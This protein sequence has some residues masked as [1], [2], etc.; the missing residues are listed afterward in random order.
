VHYPSNIATQRA[1]T[2]YRKRAWRERMK[3]TQKQSVWQIERADYRFEYHLETGLFSLVSRFGPSLSAK[4]SAIVYVS[5]N[6]TQELDSVSGRERRHS[7]EQDAAGTVLEVVTLLTEGHELVQKFRFPSGS[8]FVSMRVGF[9]AAANKPPIRAQAFRPFLIEGADCTLLLCG[10]PEHWSVYTLGYQSWSPAGAKCISRLQERPRFSIPRIM[11]YSPSH[12]V[13]RQHGAHLCDWMCAV[14]DTQTK[15]AFLAGFITLADQQG[16]ILLYTNPATGKFEYLYAETDADDVEVAS[17]GEM[18]SEELLFGFTNDPVGALV[19]YASTLGRNMNAKKWDGVPAGWCSWYKYYTRVREGDVL[20]NLVTLEQLRD[21]MPVRY[22]QL[23]DGYQRAVGDWLELDN[24]KFPCGMPFLTHRIQEAGFL[25]G[26]W[27]A[28]FFAT[29]N[30]NLFRRK[31]EMF[32][33]DRRGRIVSGGFST[34]W[35][36]RLGVLDLTHPSTLDWLREVFHTVVHQWGFRYLKLDFLYAGM[37]PGVHYDKNVTRAQAYH[38]ALRLIREVAGDDVFILGCGAPLG[39]SIGLVNGMRI[40]TDVGPSWVSRTTRWFYGSRIESS[41]ESSLVNC[42]TRSFLHDR[43]WINDP[44]CIMLRHGKLT[45]E[46]MQTFVAVLAMT[47]GIVLI[48]DDLREVDPKDLEDFRR[49][50][51]PSNIAALPIDLFEHDYPSLFLQRFPGMRYVL[52]VINWDSHPRLHRVS[53]AALGISGAFHVFDFWHQQYLGLLNDELPVTSIPPH[54]CVL[55][56]IVPDAQGPVLV[57]STLHMAQGG[58][59]VK[60]WT[61]DA[62]TKRLSA[63]LELPGHR[64]GLL[65]ISAP[66]GTRPKDIVCEQGRAEI[67]VSQNIVEVAAEFTD[68]ASFEL[69]FSPS[70]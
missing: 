19:E 43:V 32:L 41:V 16:Q 17:G 28:P 11:A 40:G 23:D 38:R 14:K 31:K 13:P 65:F 15:N 48:S 66:R 53:L 56:S 58:L 46:E 37:M 21:V 4:S 51:P 36:S 34:Q 7:V 68:A 18:L 64:S 10:S 69:T 39:P 62:S 20:T 22:M 59:E 25:P 45:R 63:R 60:H 8:G 67:H 9:R 33:R 6:E 35:R 42:V 27:L 29:T 26:L 55:F 70:P 47:G 24:T 12:E 3:N 30:S 44:D 54:G 49:M 61:W 2:H 1:G 5:G 50:M 57:S 52:A